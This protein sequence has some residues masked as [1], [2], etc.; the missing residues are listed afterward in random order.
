MAKTRSIAPTID[1]VLIQMMVSSLI[2]HIQR[3]E[4]GMGLKPISSGWKP[5]AQSIY[6]PR[7]FV[8]I[9]NLTEIDHSTLNIFPKE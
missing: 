2:Y 8:F 6:Q 7:V 3:L 4:R 5:E 9:R 1:S